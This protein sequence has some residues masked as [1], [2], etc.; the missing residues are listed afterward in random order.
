MAMGSCKDLEVTQGIS[1]H[2][3]KQLKIKHQ[4]LC[5]KVPYLATAINQLF[6]QDL[7]VVLLL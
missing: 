6:P 7:F 3:Q 2:I 5:S 4:S 1:A